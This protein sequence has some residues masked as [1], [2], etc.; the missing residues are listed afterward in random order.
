[1]KED[2]SIPSQRDCLPDPESAEAIGNP[3]AP[4]TGGFASLQPPDADC[5]VAV[6]REQDPVVTCRV[7]WR[8]EPEHP[9]AWKRQRPKD[10]R[11]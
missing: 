5:A 11:K 8:L 4:M 9:G 3:S 2:G 6:C 7:Q 10:S 1:M